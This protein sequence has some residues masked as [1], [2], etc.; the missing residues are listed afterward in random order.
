MNSSEDVIYE[1]AR[2]IYHPVFQQITT[3]REW[4][5]A[6]QRASHYLRKNFHYIRRQQI[7]GVNFNGMS[8]INRINILRDLTAY[9]NYNQMPKLLFKFGYYVFE[10]RF[11]PTRSQL[12]NA[13]ISYL[14][15]PPLSY[16]SIENQLFF[17]LL[18][19]ETIGNLI[20]KSR[21]T[22]RAV[23][24]QDLSQQTTSLTLSCNSQTMHG[25]VRDLNH[26][27]LLCDFE[28]ARRLQ[29]SFSWYARKLDN[30]PVGICTAIFFESGAIEKEK[31]F[32][33][34]RGPADVRTSTVKSIMKQH[35]VK[36]NMARMNDGLPAIADGT[37]LQIMYLHIL[38]IEFGATLSSQFDDTKKT[39]FNLIL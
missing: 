16:Q 1:T 21:N 9:A 30:I 26:F 39:N 7:F 8:S 3:G 13:R 5:Q 33:V 14:N 24:V 29:R 28:V 25:I 34:F 23:T 32:Q 38:K 36:E 11:K 17:K 12:G 31:L 10:I 18:S 19:A 20:R 6:R 2:Q 22:G 27:M 4:Y 35:L 15:R 37:E